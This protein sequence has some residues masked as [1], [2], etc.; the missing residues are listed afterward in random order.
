WT[1]PSNLALCVNPNSVYV[2]ILD[3]TKNEVFIL[4]EKRLAELYKKP[5]SYQILE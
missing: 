5:D 1:L 3:K 4:M 2:K